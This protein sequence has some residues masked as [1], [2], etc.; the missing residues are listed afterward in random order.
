MTACS[1]ICNGQVLSPCSLTAKSRYK[2]LSKSSKRNQDNAFQSTVSADICMGVLNCL[3]I[4]SCKTSTSMSRDCSYNFPK[5][6]NRLC[7]SHACIAQSYR[8]STHS[9]F[10]TWNYYRL[11]TRLDV[12]TANCATASLISTAAFTAFL[13]SKC[14]EG[15]SDLLHYY[16]LSQL[17]TL[18]RLLEKS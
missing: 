4:S 12:W 9:K 18:F 14:L 11:L 13:D 10:S 3:S 2:I 15:T 6:T 8:G 17:P 1:T 16:A 5:I 7:Q